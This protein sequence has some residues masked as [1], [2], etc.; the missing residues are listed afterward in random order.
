MPVATLASET[1]SHQ[2]LDQTLISFHILAR[3]HAAVTRRLEVKSIA[4]EGQQ[5]PRQITSTSAP[6]GISTSCLLYLYFLL[7]FIAS[8]KGRFSSFL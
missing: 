3:K 2:E 1:Y 7:T 8:N 6:S 5:N 4:L